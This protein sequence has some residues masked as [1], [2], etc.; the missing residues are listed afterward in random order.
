VTILL[1]IKKALSSA[2]AA[3]T[4]LSP[5]RSVAR[6]RE[7]L[8]APG[9]DDQA[10]YHSRC[11]EYDGESCPVLLITTSTFVHFWRNCDVQIGHSPPIASSHQCG[12]RGGGAGRLGRDAAGGHA[13][14]R[15][16]NQHRSPRS[17]RFP[18]AW[19]HHHSA[20]CRDHPAH[21]LGPAGCSHRHPPRTGRSSRDHGNRNSQLRGRKP[22]RALR[23]P[24]SRR[25]RIPHRRRAAVL[26]PERACLQPGRRGWQRPAGLYR[27]RCDLSSGAGRAATGV[28]RPAWPL[29][30]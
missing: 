6:F 25:R 26:R 18:T 20:R 16:R 9:P 14:R 2:H 24:R 12:G 29:L 4:R 28:Q 8:S 13:A 19:P 3:L 22:N 15:F 21:Q 11:W 7:M 1:P 30:R 10:V 17:T 23:L 5:T 27:R